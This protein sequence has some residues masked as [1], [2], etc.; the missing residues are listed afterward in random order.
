LGLSYVNAGAKYRDAFT[1]A[2]IAL[3]WLAVSTPR[4]MPLII[5]PPCVARLPQLRDCP[6]PI[7][8]SAGRKFLLA[9]VDNENPRQ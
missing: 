7:T 4:A 2:A 8:P 3:R 5:I 1:L 9:V 6:E